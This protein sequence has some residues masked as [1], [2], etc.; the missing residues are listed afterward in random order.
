MKSVGD[1]V[2]AGLCTGCGA[3]DICIH[4]RFSKGPWGV[5]VPMVDR[6]CTDCG[7]CLDTC[8]YR[9]DAPDEE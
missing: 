7:R 5:S 1:V 6:D 8:I 9:S 2:A 3:C 4:I